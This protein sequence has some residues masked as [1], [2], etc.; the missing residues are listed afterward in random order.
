MRSCNALASGAEGLVL[1]F[2]GA[3]VADTMI[4]AHFAIVSP[5]LQQ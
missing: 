3:R 1:R 2:E 4:K 5:A